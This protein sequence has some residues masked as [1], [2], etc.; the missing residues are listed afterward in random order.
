MLLTV[1]R[2][3][4]NSVSCCSKGAIDHKLDVELCAGSPAGKEGQKI[5]V[6]FLGVCECLWV[7]VGSA[8]GS[9]VF[10]LRVSPDWRVTPAF[11]LHCQF[12]VNFFKF[13][14]NV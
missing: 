9:S 1:G 5:L 14:M 3:I 10:S 7:G 8:S 11:C 13:G 2:F 4:K 6:R 12:I